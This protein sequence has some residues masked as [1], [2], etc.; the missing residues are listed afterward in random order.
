MS[1]A[2][3]L[4][5]EEDIPRE[6][7]AGGDAFVLALDGY[8]GPI[9]LLLTLARDQKVDLAKIS[10][11]ALA[12]QYLA[13]IERAKK[14][15]IEIAADYLVMAAWLAY[16]K[17]KLLLPSSPADAA[18]DELTGEALAEA[19]A[20]QLKRLEAMQQASQKLFDRPLLGRDR[21]ARRLKPEASLRVK[22][23][24]QAGLFDLLD[25]YGAIARRQQ[26][27]EYEV[28]TWPLVSTEEAMQ[29]LTAMLGVG[30]AAAN[31]QTM[32]RAL[33]NFLPE[34]VEDPLTRRSAYASLLTAGLEL[35]K[36][37]E[38]EIRQDGLFAPIFFRKKDKETE[39]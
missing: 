18:E 39:Q 1:A 20:F 36:Q 30:F 10:I 22:T 7:G 9:D 38:A 15:R 3:V 2:E 37:G 26:P 12:E 25:A 14:L 32:W 21:F 4:P 16:L 27:D 24:W 6:G 29:R 19:L 13:F 34:F 33:E 23:I 35:A 5:F 11:L 8:E 28:K 17:S 31:Q